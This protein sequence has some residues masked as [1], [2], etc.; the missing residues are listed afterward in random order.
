MWPFS[1]ENS[2][3][4]NYITLAPHDIFVSTHPV[5]SHAVGPLNDKTPKG[6]NQ[7]RN[8]TIKDGL[9][10]CWSYLTT[11]TDFFLLKGSSEWHR[12]HTHIYN[13]V[14]YIRIKWTE[15]VHSEV[16]FQNIHNNEN[17]AHN[18]IRYFCVTSTDKSN[19]IYHRRNCHLDHDYTINN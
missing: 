3:V 6:R 10:I 12:K 1:I 8:R 4:E 11:L 14:I 15:C 17:L 9:I 2:K 18:R 16:T 13:R 7:P 19:R 5:K